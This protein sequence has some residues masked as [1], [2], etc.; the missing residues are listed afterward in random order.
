MGILHDDG[1]NGDPVA[2]DGNFTLVSTF[3]EF[4]VGPISLQVTASAAGSTSHA[5]SPLATLTVTGTPPP[6]VTITAPG[7]LSYLNLSPTTVN[8]TV[9]DPKATVVINSVA[10][11]VSPNGSF[12]AQIPLAEGPNIVT[13]T[14]TSTSGAAGTA[15]IT[16]TLDTTPPH[17]TITSPSDQ[18]VTTASSLSVAGNV[19]DT[20]VGTVNSQ[21]AQVT[22]NGIASQVAN[23]TFLAMNVPLNM[24][25]NVVTAVAVDR[26]G[27]SATT[28]ITVIRQAP[29]PG[30]DSVDLRETIRRGSSGARF[31][32]RF[33][34]R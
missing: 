20:V 31:R 1:L 4:A 21:Q 12:S 2:N 34:F 30:T 8:G 27:N 15:S 19:N 14:A 13:A 5:F 24:G 32:R 17:V 26:A 25:S 10:A 29:Q 18:F 6:T 22:V 33:W 23:R 16:V 3:T 7:N 28:Q 11:A 9:S